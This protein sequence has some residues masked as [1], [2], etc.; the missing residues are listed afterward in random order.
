M[1]PRLFTE[2]M[3]PKKLVLIFSLLLAGMQVLAQQPSKTNFPCDK[4][5]YSP[6][7]CPTD[8]AMDCDYS[9]QPVEKGCN[10]F[11]GDDNDGDGLVDTADPDC[12]KYYGVDYVVPG[13]GGC[14]LPPAGGSPFAGMGPPAVS[15]QNTSD[16]QSKVAVGDITGDGVPDAVI[17]SKWNRNV[18]VVATKQL[19]ATIKA[20][21]VIAEF[22]TPGDQALIAGNAHTRYLFE[23]E[24]LIADIDGDGIGEIFTVISGRGGNNNTPPE[25]FFLMAFRFKPGNDPLKGTLVPFWL[26]K[27][28]APAG[29]AAVDLGPNRPGIFGIADMDG[30]GL[31]E[32]Y[33]RNRIYAAE[34][35]KLL[36]DGGGDW[37][38]DINAA[39]V[40]VDI[41]KDDGGRME[42]VCGHLIYKI[43]MLTAR[44][45]Q[46]L[47]LWKN[48]NETDGTKPGATPNLTFTRTFSTLNPDGVTP[49]GAPLPS[50][51]Y[52]YFTKV[53]LDPLE[54]GEDSHTSTSVADVDG[55]G[56][57]D[58]VFTGAI[59][60]A[61]DTT[62][63]FYWNVAQNSVAIYIPQDPANPRGWT[64]GTGRVNL[65]RAN[66]ADNVLDLTF[67]AGNRLHCITTDQYTG[68]NGLSL[69]NLWQQPRII[70][71]S[72]SGI[73][74]VTLY[75]FDNDQ[76]NELVYRDSQQLVVVDAE[77]GQNVLFT[78]VCK[79][80][81]YT[82]GPIIADVNG[83]GATDICVPCYRNDGGTLADNLQDQSLAEVRLYYSTAT[84]WLPT[85]KVWNQPGYFVVNINDD[86][87]LPF[88]QFAQTT[89]F[90]GN[91]KGGN[92][93]ETFPFNVFLNQVPFM[94][95]DGCPTF[96][97]PN[98]TFAGNPDPNHPDYDPNNPAVV[99]VP[100]T[101]G[102]TTL[103][104]YFK[105]VNDG[106]VPL[107]GTIPISFFSGDPSLPGTKRLLNANIIING[108]GVG[109]RD[110]SEIFYI[111]DPAITGAP[112]LLWVILYADHNATLPIVGTGVLEGTDRANCEDTDKFYYTMVY[113][114]SLIAGIEHVQDNA[115]C[116]DATLEAGNGILRARLY[117]PVDHDNDPNTPMVAGEEITN[118]TG[119]SFQW[120]TGTDITDPSAVI[121]PPDGTN[122]QITGLKGDVVDINLSAPYTLVITEN[123]YSGGYCQTPQVTEYIA[124]EWLLPDVIIEWVSDQTQCTPPNGELKAVITE[125][126]DPSGFEFEWFRTGGEP[127]NIF[128]TVA[129][130]LTTGS[131]QV[132]IRKYDG[133]NVLLCE[134]FSLPEFVDQPQPLQL[135][136]TPTEI[137]SCNDLNGGTITAMAELYDY[138]TQSYFQTA[139][140]AQVTF[141]FYFF[142]DTSPVPLPSTPVPA[143][144]ALAPIHGTDN[145][146]R[147]GLPEGTY[148]VNAINNATQCNTYALVTIENN[149][150]APLVDAYQT[151]IQT[152][153][154][155][156]LPNGIVEADVWHGEIGGTGTQ[157]N[158]EYDF[159]WYE[160]QS[161]LGTP[162]STDRVAS[163]VKGNTLYTV[164]VVNKIN[165]C[166]ITDTVWVVE[167]LSY[168]VVTLT[169]TPNSI[170]DPTAA[171]GG[172][173]V[174]AM[175]ATV[176]FQGQDVTLPDPNFTVTWYNDTYENPAR[177]NTDDAG[178]TGSLSQLPGD[179][180]FNDANDPA[181]WYYTI[182]VEEVNV[183]C[184]SAP[185]TEAV[186]YEP[187]YPAIDAWTV[188]STNCDVGSANDNGEI[189]ALVDLEGV[190]G[191]GT[192]DAATATSG[193]YKF[194]W[195]NGQV[196]DP[197]QII[198]PLGNEKFN[199]TG[200]SYYIVEVTN[201]TNGCVSTMP[202]YV[203]TDIQIPVLAVD[204]VPNSI[205]D[206]TLTI[207]PVPYNGI[208]RVVSVDY[209]GTLYDVN[210]PG[211]FNFVWGKAANTNYSQVQYE[212]IN[213]A[214]ETYTVRV[215]DPVLNCTS[216][217]IIRDILNEIVPVNID[218]ITVIASTNCTPGALANGSLTIT[219]IDT[220]NPD[221]PPYTIEW[222]NDV[223]VNFA[224]AT[225]RAKVNS[226]FYDGLQG[227][228]GEFYTVRV[229][230]NSTGCYDVEVREVPDEQELPVI[231]V[232][233]NPNT[234][235]VGADGEVFITSLTYKNVA[236]ADPANPVNYNYTYSWTGTAAG[237]G[238]VFSGRM[239]GTYT[240]RVTNTDLGC[241]SDPED[242]IVV[243]QLVYPDIVFDP[244]DPQ[245]SCDPNQLN[246]AIT[247]SID[248]NGDFI[249]DAVTGYTYA[250]FT[251][252]I[253]TN[254]ASPLNTAK[255]DPTDSRITF[256]LAGNTYYRAQATNDVTGCVRSEDVFLPEII[257][258]PRI[259]VTAT[260]ILDCQ[261]PGRVDA[262]VFI[263]AD[264]DGDVDDAEDVNN[265]TF[266]WYLGVDDTGT[267]Q[268][269]VT[270]SFIDN[271]SIA[272][273]YAAKAISNI[274]HCETD[275]D[276]DRVD[277]P[278]PLFNIMT[279]VNF[280][281]ASCAT[282][283]G[284][285]TAYVDVSGVPTVA[286]YTFEW[287]SGSITNPPATFYTVPEVEFGPLLPP[288]PY[289]FYGKTYDGMQP[290]VGFD[291]ANP[292]NPYNDPDIHYPTPAGAPPTYQDPATGATLFGYPSGTY[293]VVVTDVATTCREYH[294]AYLPFEE[295][296][297]IIVAEVTP[298]DCNG[299]NGAI[300]VSIGLPDGRTD[301]DNY[302]IWL[303]DGSNPT[304]SPPQRYDD[305][306]V[307]RDKREPAIGGVNPP[308]TGL[309][310]GIYTVVAQEDPAKLYQT[311]CFS[312][313]VQVNLVQAQ[314]PLLTALSFTANT[315]CVEA[316]EDGNGAIEVEF[317]I[318]PDDPNH[319]NYPP[320]TPPAVYNLL[321]QT[322]TVEARDASDALVFTQ[323]GIVPNP[324]TANG[325]ALIPN[326]RNEEY[327]IRVFTQAT[328]GCFTEKPYEVPWQPSVPTIGDDVSIDESEYCNPAFEQSARVQ[329][330]R[331]VV[332]G[333]NVNINDYYFEWFTDL[334]LT[335]GIFD[336]NGN[337]GN[338][339]GEVLSNAQ[340]PSKPVTGYPTAGVSD[341]PG[342]YWVRAS[343]FV[344]GPGF[345]CPS[346]SFGV[347]IPDASI[348]PVVTLTPSNDTS[349]ETNGDFEGTII[350]LVETASG[351]GSV[352]TPLYSYDWDI[353]ATPGYS[354]S[355]DIP[356]DDDFVN[357]A[358]N[359]NGNEV[360]DG[361]VDHFTNLGPAT[362]TLTAY[363]NITGCLDNNTRT[364]QQSSLPIII[365]NADPTDQDYCNPNN[366]RID[367]IDVTVG[368]VNNGGVNY[369][370]GDHGDF[371]FSWYYNDPST[372]ELNDVNSGDQINGDVLAADA[373]ISTA[374]Y[375]YNITTSITGE[376][377]YVKARRNS[378]APFGSG[379]VSAPIPMVVYDKRVLP[380]VNF[381]TKANRAC[382]DVGFDG[383]IT[384]MPSTASGPG[385][386]MNYWYEWQTPLPH[387][388]V[389]V[390]DLLIGD[391]ADGEPML[392]TNY[393]NG[394]RVA[395]GE[396]FINVTNVETGCSRI[397]SVI[398][399]D[400]PLPV[401]IWDYDKDNQLLCYP[402][403]RIT[404]VQLREDGTVDIQPSE[405]VYE[406]YFGSYTEGT[407]LLRENDDPSGNIITG[408]EIIANYDP[409]IPDITGNYP[410]VAG[411]YYVVG[412]KVGT[413]QGTGGGCRTPAFPVRID[414]IKDDPRITFDE[415]VPNS[416]CAGDPNGSITATA[417]ELVAA[418]DEY[419]FAWEFN[420][421]P[422]ALPTF[423]TPLGVDQSQ[424]E[425][426]GEGL[427][428]L[429]VTNTSRTGCSFTSS[430]PV[431]KNLIISKPSIIDFNRELPRDCNGGQGFVEVITIFVG[432]QPP[433]GIAYSEGD[434]PPFGNEF[435]FEWYFGSV[436]NQLGETSHRVEPAIAGKYYVL[437]RKLDTQCESDLV[438]VTLDDSA[439]ERPNLSLS[440][441]KLQIT[442]LDSGLPPSG[443]LTASALTNL[444][445][446]DPATY[447]Y[448]WYEG[449]LDNS[450]NKVV[451]SETPNVGVTYV[452][453]D[454]PPERYFVRVYD[455]STN[456]TDSLYYIVPDNS[457]QFRP[458]IAMG[459]SPVTVC[460][461]PPDG[462]VQ[463]RVI[464]TDVFTSQA[465]LNAISPNS[466]NL[467]ADFYIGDMG[468]VILNN[469]DSVLTAY[470]NP[471]TGVTDNFSF[472]HFELDEGIYTI[473]ITDLNT[474]CPAIG[475]IEVENNRV[476][477]EVVAEVEFPMTN[478]DNT[479]P[480]GQLTATADGKVAGYTF[481]WSTV[482][483]PGTVLS[484]TNKLIGVLHDIEY[485]VVAVNISSG[486]PGDDTEFVPYFPKQIPAPNV[487]ALQHWTSCLSP[488]GL[489]MADVNGETA[490]FRFEWFNNTV[491]YTPSSTP[492]FPP[493]PVDE[494]NDITYL[495]DNLD[496]N[497]GAWNREYIS[498]VEI[499]NNS[500][501]DR[502]TFGNDYGVRGYEYATGCYTELAKIKIFDLRV[503]PQVV[504]ETTP[505]YCLEPSGTIL[506]SGNDRTPLVVKPPVLPRDSTFY[507]LVFLQDIQWRFIDPPNSNTEVDLPGGSLVN[508]AE[509][510]QVPA[511][512]YRAYYET[513]EGCIGNADVIVGTEIRDYNL[514]SV[515]GD[516][517]N[518]YFHIDCINNFRVEEGARRDNN[519]KIFNR[520]GVLVYEADAYD[521]NE[522][523]FTGYGQRVSGR[524]N[525]KFASGNG[526]YTMG[527]LLPDGTYF[528]IIDKRDGSRPKTGY[529]ELVR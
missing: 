492:D 371:T 304:L 110:S 422:I 184:P 271:I 285:I 118:Y 462:L 46:P 66:F 12:F 305:Y 56:V 92:G 289:N 153:C 511:G 89:G 512:T 471:N 358:G 257:K 357:Y 383:E 166:S 306:A 163:A 464:N 69:V 359:H 411:Q 510:L 495:Y 337:E 158:A 258:L 268:V 29:R 368:D 255:I 431:V 501:D 443:E 133:D 404:I 487:V 423:V 498:P 137:V 316:P 520:Y 340:N 150:E 455:P 164:M 502:Y 211:N 179:T 54:Y 165:Q 75:D 259:E 458:Q 452:L 221:S 497:G 86:L 76:H 157:H 417:Y 198:A 94:G 156:N 402:D 466:L 338:D 106:N 275:I 302:I 132:Q 233:A 310:S 395:P 374:E 286:G 180:R 234:M 524:D 264:D 312:V 317:A 105:Y 343:R 216:D 453:G 297:F 494:Y 139:D 65:G 260:D 88:P 79:S 369:G 419:A 30:D 379:C 83:D 526:L 34:S 28:G 485:K 300:S 432:G 339:G 430:I 241:T 67:I 122:Y 325:T 84:Q 276:T 505:S 292:N 329:I 10:C 116:S 204:V 350:V 293:T 4:R 311:G 222:F 333:N 482:S 5:N 273:S 506:L 307:A 251:V 352:G 267:L 375:N 31:A 386:G 93:L 142:D 518:E 44:T 42:L 408:P 95:A 385:F 237:S 253:N 318:H 314:P 185:V 336:A 207:P 7:D 380:D 331:I 441:T 140:P 319:P 190:G 215:T 428:T 189:H 315:T 291:Q 324:V 175:V 70:N 347:V 442:C 356:Q 308:F 102:E 387:P 202:V 152:S 287:H 400:L 80:H 151:Q 299:D 32:V 483:D 472:V 327:N 426:A 108:L 130:G 416:T 87:T 522:V 49:G 493:P 109:V 174:G 461:I 465:Y 470:V 283:K 43:P 112:F 60:S 332:G 90:T 120:Y 437:T 182:V 247:A 1:E 243:D 35:G 272:N 195:Y 401:Q 525:A 131:Y 20:G 168:P 107:S 231:T 81:T 176:Q 126:F 521:N 366:A 478:C 121:A 364:I 410:V 513:Y 486:C 309:P 446:S 529:L 226:P 413:A 394:D 144:S 433:V 517:G 36:A 19:S 14:G 389:V 378:G 281:P 407:N 11:D 45:L 477:P 228:V 206:P 344:P 214:P 516:G 448:T 52:R 41:S 342:S 415:V 353:V 223:V 217:I 47:T 103:G 55:D 225:P 18:R 40:A 71:D 388:N 376:T 476:Y 397:A 220:N 435:E 377:Y 37:D 27:G 61:T 33:L 514:V 440:L 479:K 269:G 475:D 123:Q 393:D 445:D 451:D 425:E 117:K 125:G 509:V 381:A 282:D 278:G 294:T 256:T 229:I 469:P 250:W 230:D 219:T 519:V 183:H 208:Y 244:T 363:N 301:Y 438:E 252:D 320:L 224:P 218:D 528:Y 348:N 146:F 169:P 17:T 391:D 236:E 313:P 181:P 205:C 101:C 418:T 161:T 62:A 78:R 489:L 454:L 51:R 335:D 99:V 248:T 434:I 515:N 246:G 85:R 39:P 160:G 113:P 354:L 242:A 2:Q 527:D 38:R 373:Y 178:Q 295:E 398:V 134:S 59:N 355:S 57:I 322:F 288:D 367:V 463:G 111:S 232:D 210:T 349:C 372:T 507:R 24:V 334:N 406:W 450:G 321:P 97:L 162:Y 361:D 405:F 82:E 439:V 456:C 167:Q 499:T 399:P 414:Q 191:D 64:W 203:A 213:Q 197:A 199:R 119:Y 429:T 155:P 436:T 421:G 444:P 396:Y 239:A 270:G 449:S 290:I 135:L 382:D 427:Y 341:P 508:F 240:L 351:P 149:L 16:T 474:G 186:L 194:Q 326:L 124:N 145:A 22:D 98:L 201:N 96:P 457:P 15:G 53:Y 447:Q 490:G 154:D 496:D 77:T 177:V 468:T 473:R 384:V 235:C 504:F 263:D 50:K 280:K 21:D 170:C 227:G 523:K 115:F 200:D 13:A 420:N 460:Y 403:G 488:N 365:V 459:V 128:G 346:P 265:Y 26:G 23:H 491:G 409:S 467:R 481:E 143:G 127:L 172:Q 212:L 3:T 298:D 370:P 136:T 147:Y 330:E 277:Q 480:N 412:V 129:A 392:Q 100:P 261:T 323:S 279:E 360:N 484:T 171:T 238:P 254:I 500:A 48:M 138:S 328:A 73:L 173:Y 187:D 296:P 74:T 303:I 148:V 503:Y 284:V 249:G 362:Y 91:C 8:P 245:T 63:I 58:V 68:G 188:A 9:G 6:Q 104:V 141:G 274:T 196:I 159:F 345:G 424:V 25:R 72:K 192:G 266:T 209:R 114:V 390:T 193:D 262:A